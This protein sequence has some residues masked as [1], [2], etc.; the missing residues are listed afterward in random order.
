MAHDFFEKRFSDL[1]EFRANP[2]NRR[3]YELPHIY[4]TSDDR[5]IVEFLESE[6]GWFKLRFKERSSSY[7]LPYEISVLHAGLVKKRLLNKLNLPLPD[8]E[9][10]SDSAL[11]YQYFLEKSP[12]FIKKTSLDNEISY[13]SE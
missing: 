6:E 2:S 1:G 13:G 10:L 7:S 12:G 8:N 9:S 3:Q 11:L 4:P 5:S